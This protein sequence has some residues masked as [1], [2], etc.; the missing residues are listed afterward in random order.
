MQYIAF[1]AH[2][3]Y[4]WAR[5]ERADGTVVRER[6]IL[7]ERGALRQFLTG[8]EPGSPVAV[9]TVGNWYWIVDEIEAAGCQPQLVHA[10]KAKL[11]LGTVNKTD[12]LDARGLVR[13]QRTGTLPVV[14]IPPRELRDARELPRTRMVLVAQRTRLKNRI[15]ASL[16]KYGILLPDVSDLFGQRGRQ[17]LRARMSELPPH[18]GFVVSRLLEQ[19]EGLDREI[20]GLERRMKALFAVDDAMRFLMTLP[21]VGFILGTVIG[22]E[23][24]DVGRFG[25]HEQLAA[26]AGTVP[27]VHE[28]GGRRHYGPVRSDVNRYLKWAFVE[29]ANGVCRTRRLHRERHTS[30]LYERIARRRGHQKAIGAVA[31]H[32]AEAAYWML[33]KGEPYRDPGLSRGA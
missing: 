20:A 13:L 30:R 3:H 28:S 18:T 7:H 11:M 6:K 8:S 27:R 22:T 2:K 14:W 33:T 26:Y 19:V 25:R 9:E 5:V 31:R 23:I 29:A 10:R 15:H 24:G 21:G 1:D 17:E 12:R 4:T 16:N 32:L